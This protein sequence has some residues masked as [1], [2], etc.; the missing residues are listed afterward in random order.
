MLATRSGEILRVEPVPVTADMFSPLPRPPSPPPPPPRRLI[1]P[2]DVDQIY[3]KEVEVM[4]I[5]VDEPHGESLNP[6][7]LVLSEP[8]PSVDVDV[9]GETEVERGTTE[10][11]SHDGS[12]LVTFHRKLCTS[13][14]ALVSLSDRPEGPVVV[15]G[16]SDSW[17]IRGSPGCQRAS[18]VRLDAPSGILTATKFSPPG[19]ASRR[20]G[21]SML[22]VIDGR[23]A[24][25][26]PNLEQRDWARTG[27]CL[28]PSFC[29]RTSPRAAR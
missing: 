17:L 18:A 5:G 19:D 13:P 28:T 22:A 11:A 14:L 24:L 4:N 29:A 26:S 9:R 3:G 27:G 21:E 12:L 25:V 7:E 2:E 1:P 23:L 15:L 16:H 20:V 10:A 8:K 6:L